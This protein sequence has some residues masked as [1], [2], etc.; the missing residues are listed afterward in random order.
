MIRYLNQIIYQFKI[1][2]IHLEGVEKLL[3]QEPL[4]KFL[5]VDEYL[6]V[7][8]NKQPKYIHFI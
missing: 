2:L 5:P 3:K 4:K 1:V 6:P 7:M 8:F